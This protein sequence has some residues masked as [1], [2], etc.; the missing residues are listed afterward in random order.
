MCGIFQLCGP[1]LFNLLTSSANFHSSWEYGL[2]LGPLPNFFF[3]LDSQN[4]TTNSAC[5]F[6]TRRKG[7]RGLRN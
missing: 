2:F 3:N 6:F 7:I 5:R 4:F 1:L